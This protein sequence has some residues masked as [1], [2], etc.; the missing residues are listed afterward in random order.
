MSRSAVKSV[1][2]ITVVLSVASLAYGAVRALVDTVYYSLLSQFL[3]QAFPTYNFVSQ[4]EQYRALCESLDVWATVL[5]CVVVGVLCV[6]FDNGRRESVIDETGGFYR[7]KQGCE[8]Y[9]HNYA[10]SDVVASL[11]APVPLLALSLIPLSEQAPRLIL[12]AFEALC[13]PLNAVAAVSDMESAAATLLVA[14]PVAVASILAARL[15]AAPIALS[16]WR[17]EWLSDTGEV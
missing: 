8:D 14:Y 4:K 13:R 2:I 6:V 3:P 12:R 16:R 7:I 11:V 10:V 9:Y 1:A 17:A 15:L 5:L